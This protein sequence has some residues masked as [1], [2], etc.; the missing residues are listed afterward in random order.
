MNYVSLEEIS[1]H[2]SNNQKSKF[3][4]YVSLFTEYNF[5]TNLISKNDM[6]FLFEKHIYDSLAFNLFVKKFNMPDNIIDIGTGGGFPSVP[7]SLIYDKT[8]IYAI[9]SI[10]KKINFI[11]TVKNELNIKNLFPVNSRI[12]NLPVEYRNNFG[13][14]TTRALG[15]LSLILEYAA[16]Y[17]KKNGYFVA[18][19]S[20]KSDSEL[21]MAESVLKKYNIK[22]VDIIDYK[23]PLKESY[24]RKLMIFCK[25]NDKDASLK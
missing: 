24:D 20:I 25:N 16:P 7:L 8:K 6:K 4:K 1:V 10:A 17:I 19:K 22:L 3:D 18:Y 11:N 15:K 14:V 21:N 23:L 12:E 5:H 13:V 9:D 2:L